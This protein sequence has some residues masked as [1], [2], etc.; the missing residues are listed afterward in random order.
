MPQIKSNSWVKRELQ[1][2]QKR[3]MDNLT[4][5][6]LNFLY[7]DIHTD[8]NEAKDVDGNYLGARQADIS[9]NTTGSTNNTQLV[10]SLNRLMTTK[11]IQVELKRKRKRNDPAPYFSIT[12]EGIKSFEAIL[13]LIGYSVDVDD[14]KNRESTPIHLA[15]ECFD[16]I[17]SPLTRKPF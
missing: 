2:S 5:Q 9:K 15:L 7:Y 3:S 12:E 16:G 13:K 4:L 11:L 10:K 17:D 6:V 1:K 8:Q 14:S